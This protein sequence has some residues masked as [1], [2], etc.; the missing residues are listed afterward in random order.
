LKTRRELSAIE[1]ARKAALTDD[2]SPRRVKFADRL[3]RQP[4]KNEA[5]LWHRLKSLRF[6]W[7]VEIWRQTVIENYILDF[8]FP[9][10]YLGVELDGPLHDP[11]K[12]SRRDAKLLHRGVRI[13]RFPNPEN[14]QELTDLIYKISTEVNFQK[15]RKNLGNPQNW[16][17][18][19]FLP[20]PDTKNTFEPCWND[21]YG[22]NVE[23][24]RKS[25]IR[26]G[27]VDAKLCGNYVRPVNKKPGCP[28]QVFASAEVAEN[29]LR[30]LKNSGVVATIEQC[31]ICHRIHIKNVRSPE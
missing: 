14:K 29:E 30:R 21:E 11:E 10:L 22:G 31:A 19:S 24:A 13:I 8:Y 28:R 5:L 25:L 15:N 2:P 26:E 17:D 1:R 9:D 23:K 20:P 6:K 3:R 27:L 16:R 12:D 7:D 4:T 18:S